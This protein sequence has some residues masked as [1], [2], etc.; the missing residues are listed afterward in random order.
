MVGWEVEGTLKCISR[1]N[2]ITWW[3]GAAGAARSQGG[4]SLR[5]GNGRRPA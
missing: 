4:A 3:S 5:P 2:E 1:V